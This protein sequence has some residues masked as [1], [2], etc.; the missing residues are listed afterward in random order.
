MGRWFDVSAFPLLYEGSRKVAILFTDI[1]DRKKAEEALK[2]SESNLPNTILQA[3]VAMAILKGPAFVVEIANDRMYELWG[4][5]K[6][7]AFK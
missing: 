1:S 2:L 6:D 4:R 3:P 7:T 5:G